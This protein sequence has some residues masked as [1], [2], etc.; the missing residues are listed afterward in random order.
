MSLGYDHESAAPEMEPEGSLE[1]Q[2]SSE[3]CPWVGSP[4]LTAWYV[5]AGETLGFATG[6]SQDHILRVPNPL[7]ND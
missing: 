2:P 5:S 1:S 4:A 7:G 6:G 3:V